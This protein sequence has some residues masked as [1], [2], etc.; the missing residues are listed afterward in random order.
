M[1][2]QP[3]QKPQA[4]VPTTDNTRLLRDAFGQFA[5][6]VTIVTTMSDE[7]AVAITANSFTSVSLDPAIV[8]WSADTASF[9]FPFFRSAQ[10]YAIHVLSASQNDLCWDVVK[11]ATALRQL[12][13]SENQEGVPVIDGCL[14][15]FE[16]VQHAVHPA[17]D[18]EIIL[19]KVLRAEM[20]K[21]E[22]ALTFFGGKVGELAQPG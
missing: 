15:R 8:L 9:R 14:A 20:N 13:L 6:G 19:G 1:H 3:L 12:T 18:H 17:G 16:C 4:F 2:V 22:K 7:G 11:D 5:T 10:H 21:A